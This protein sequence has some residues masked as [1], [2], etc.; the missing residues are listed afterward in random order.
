MD[1]ARQQSLLMFEAVQR[2]RDGT[3][4]PVEVSSRFLELD[5]EG[6]FL[7]IVRDARERKAAEGRIALLNRTLRT[8]SEVNQLM[9]RELDR[10]RFL[11]EAC[12]ILVGHGGF[13]MAWVG[14]RDPQTDWIVPLA[15]AGH[16]EGYPSGRPGSA[17]TGP[18]PGPGARGHGP[19]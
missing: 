7:S 14:F 2:A 19:A 18:R 1:A 4:L 11:Q 16:E 13:R 6:L 8:L 10:E 5:G 15:W 12:R 3:P 9:V 17:R